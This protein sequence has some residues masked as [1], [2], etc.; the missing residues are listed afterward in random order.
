MVPN[1]YLLV[2]PTFGSKQHESKEKSNNYDERFFQQ[3]S[4]RTF[5]NEYENNNT[6]TCIQGQTNCMYIVYEAM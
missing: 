3:S 2:L 4:N 1:F 6:E 5:D